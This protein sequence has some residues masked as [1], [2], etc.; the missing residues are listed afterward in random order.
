MNK[1]KVNSTL[2]KFVVS[3]FAA[4]IIF[5]AII[6][7]Q[8]KIIY[9]AGKATAF[10][11]LKDIDKNTIITKD[12]LNTYFKQ[13]EVS[14]DSLIDAAVS[15]KKELIN[16][17][18]TTNVVKNQQISEKNINDNK[19]EDIKNPVEGSI[20]TDDISQV[21]GGIIRPGDKINIISTSTENPNSP[22]QKIT[23]AF[24][25]KDILVNKVFTSDG[26]EINR[27]DG[28]KYAATV[29]NLYLSSE[30]SLKLENAISKGKIKVVKVL[31]N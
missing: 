24:T 16:K 25:L 10:F 31:D 1:V 18:V 8:N 28:N 30:D 5:I 11:A 9:P 21:D 14:R 26:K 3:V 12:N 22:E 27:E 17:Y 4:A 19:T 2:S 6:F 23:T 15:S 7:L 29:L 20:K 13:E